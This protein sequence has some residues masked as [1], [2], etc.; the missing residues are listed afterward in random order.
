MPLLVAERRALHVRI[1]GEERARSR[2]RTPPVIA[3]RWARRCRWACPSRCSSQSP[4]P[5]ASWCGA[6][7]ARTARSPPRTWRHG[8]GLGPGVVDGRPAAPGQSGRVVEGEFRPGGHG[9]EWCDAEVL[10]ALRRRSLARLRQEVEPVEPAVLARFLV[11]WHGIGRRAP[12]PRRAARRRRTA[13]G[14]AA[15][16]LDARAASPAGTHRRL[17][18]IAARHADFGGRGAVARRRAARRAR[19]T[20]RAVTSPTTPRRCRPRMPTARR[21]RTRRSRGA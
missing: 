1:A 4:T 12:R 16:C 20:H 10:R 6:T 21:T 5:S 13:A 15:G 2:S 19:R 7:R 17:R 3:T 18:T 11:N 8:F 14:R 9:R